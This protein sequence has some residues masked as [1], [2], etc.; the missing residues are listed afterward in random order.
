MLSEVERRVLALHCFDHAVATCE[1]CVR[2]YAF[3]DLGV[4]VLGR[5]YY[6][7]P[8]CR[9]DLI[10]QLRRHI[11]GCLAITRALDE[12]I[13]RSLEAIKETQRLVTGSAILAAESR[14]LAKRVLDT[15]RDSRHVPTTPSVMVQIAGVL[16]KRPYI[17]ADSWGGVPASHQRRSR[18]RSTGCAPTF[19]SRSS[20]ECAGSA[21]VRTSY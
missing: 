11:L 12:R 8:S 19:A 13:T 18:S 6:F 5:R 7:C 3:T 20:V 17:C 2:D 14:E 1:A 9:F 10:D 16:V 21:S 15:K 4:D